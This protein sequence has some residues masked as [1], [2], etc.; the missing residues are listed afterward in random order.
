[1]NLDG[2]VMMISGGG[3]GIGRACAVAFARFGARVLLMGRRAESLEE[4]A[5]LVKAA[6]GTAVT[7]VGDVTSEKARRAAIAAAQH[8]FGGLDILINNAGIVVASRLQ[9]MADSDIQRLIDV[10]LTAPILLTKLALP[11]LLQR[12]DAAVVNISSGM[13]LIGLPFYTAYTATKAGIARFGEALRRELGPG[14]RCLTVYPTG[15]ETPMMASSRI[16][17]SEGVTLETPESVAEAIVDG[18]RNDVLE[19]IRGGPS[20]HKMIRDTIEDP[21]SVD[22]HFLRLRESLEKA[23]ADHRSV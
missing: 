12:N 1:M 18:L 8:S 13:G 14:L 15:T 3:S 20:R 22:A 10:N 9:A 5:S 21:A 17:A 16:G 2:R 7:V 4:T 19:V 6:G 23:T 11:L